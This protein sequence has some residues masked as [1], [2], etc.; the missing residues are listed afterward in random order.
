M[1]LEAVLRLYGP[2]V[3]GWVAAWILWRENT[4]N[5]DRYHEEKERDIEIKVKMFNALEKL[6][7]A[8]K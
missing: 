8:I 5:A 3:M 2:L 6:T 4:R 1:E 7:E